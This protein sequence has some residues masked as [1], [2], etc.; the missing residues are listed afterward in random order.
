MTT[1][2]FRMPTHWTSALFNGDTSGLDE[3]DEADLDAA[4]AEIVDTVGHALPCDMD[5]ENEF[6]TGDNADFP[7][8]AVAGSYADFHFHS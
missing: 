1:F 3:A 7:F 6:E 5:N 8:P 2:T 4:I